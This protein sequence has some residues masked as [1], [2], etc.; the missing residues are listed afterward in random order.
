MKLFVLEVHIDD[1]EY[2]EIDQ[3]IVIAKTLDNALEFA[4]KERNV[5]WEVEKEIKL[6]D[7]K[8]T[9]HVLTNI[10]PG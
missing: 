7:V 9:T 3:C 2:D 4:K 1:F 10:F 8:E 6:E 5:R